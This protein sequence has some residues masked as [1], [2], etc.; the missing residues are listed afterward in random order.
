[1]L[2]ALNNQWVN[3]VY[4]LSTQSGTTGEWLSPIYKTVVQNVCN[5]SHNQPVLPQ[6]LP[7][8]KPHLSPSFFQRITLVYDRLYTQS[9]VPTIKKIKKK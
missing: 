2:N 7:A 5:Q 6:L 1:M 4:K 9:T 8:F 3:N